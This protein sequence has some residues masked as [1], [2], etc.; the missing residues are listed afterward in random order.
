M[1][2]FKEI[3]YSLDNLTH[4]YETMASHVIFEC[5]NL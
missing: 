3:N 2:V 5:L 4:F 1:E